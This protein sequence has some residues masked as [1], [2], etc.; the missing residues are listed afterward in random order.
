MPDTVRSVECGR[1]VL[2]VDDEPTVLRILSVWLEREGYA[3]VGASDGSEA[4]QTLRTSQFDLLITDL[5]MPGISGLELISLGRQ[6]DPDLAV[7][8]A[9]ALDDRSVAS[10]AL[11]LGAFG[12]V[13]KPFD[14]N[15][16]LV[17]VANALARR[18]LMQIKAVYERSLEDK[19]RDRTREI[20]ARE[21]ELTL[22]LV[23]AAELRDEE[24]GAHIRRVGLICAAIATDLGWGVT[25]VEDIGLAAP[26]HDIGKIGIPDR[27]LLKPGELTP[28]E[29]E[30]MRKH[31]E[32]GARILANA[33]SSVV[34]MASDI[35]LMHHER[36]D[37]TGYPFGLFEKGIAQSARIT[38][39]A[40]VLDA[41]LTD[42]VY[43]PAFSEDE[44]LTMMRGGR[45]TQFDPVVLDCALDLYPKLR[46]I[47]NEVNASCI[48]GVVLAGAGR[49]NR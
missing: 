37:G 2:L 22:R 8:V 23:A 45:G 3:C 14:E 15:E 46:T 38:S 7:I 16:I 6:H 17:A 13:V 1:R 33:S 10:E 25:D 11:R 28:K 36:W 39:V 35:A 4:W 34:R 30:V 26:M 5:K 42:R 12:Y 19:V 21:V 20:R 18:E 29:Q 32:I 47:R 40:D 41:L 49:V 24:T 27:I 9:T 43:R 44:M 31:T 48:E